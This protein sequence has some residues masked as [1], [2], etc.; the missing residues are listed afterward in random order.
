ML[1]LNSTSSTPPL[2]DLMHTSPIASHPPLPVTSVI[3]TISQSQIGL[4]NP[5]DPPSAQLA[6]SACIITSNPTQIR[7]TDREIEI[8]EVLN[9]EELQAE[10]NSIPHYRRNIGQQKLKRRVTEIS[11]QTSP[12]QAKR[13]VGLPYRYRQGKGMLVQPPNTRERR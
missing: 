4:V 3:E 6:E 12:T 7:G 10:S 11:P 9:E 5:R 1:Q 8:V 13:N 2:V